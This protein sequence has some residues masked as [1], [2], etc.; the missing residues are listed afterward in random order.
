MKVRTVIVL[1]KHS[2]RQTEPSLKLCFN[3]KIPATNK[4]STKS[5]CITA[6]IQKGISHNSHIKGRKMPGHGGTCFS[7][8]TEAG[9]SEFKASL[10]YRVSS[11]RAKTKK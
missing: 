4:M 7:R 6:G 8:E 5:I 2:H 1:G 3:R 11:R 9:G 10:V